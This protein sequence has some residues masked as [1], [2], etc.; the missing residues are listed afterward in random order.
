MS[1]A[2]CSM[3][4][5]SSGSVDRWVESSVS[6]HAIVEGRAG[7]QGVEVESSLERAETRCDKLL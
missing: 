7:V 4:R 3:I 6:S 5:I 1:A 2:H